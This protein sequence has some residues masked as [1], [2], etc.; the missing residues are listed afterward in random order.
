MGVVSEL[1]PRCRASRYSA[2][3]RGV[4]V[5]R[6]EIIGFIYWGPPLRQQPVDLRR[7]RVLDHTISSPCFGRQ[8]FNGDEIQGA[9]SGTA[10]VLIFASWAILIGGLTGSFSSAMGLD[11]NLNDT[12]FVVGTFNTHGRRR[13]DAS[14]GMHFGAEDEGPSTTRGGKIAARLVSSASTHVFPSSLATWAAGRNRDRRNS[15][16]FKSCRGGRG[17]A[18]GR[19]HDDGYI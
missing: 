15:S 9:I 19:L 16:S 13:R 1:V 18:R 10:D 8:E 7:S 11:I 4:I 14:R 12:Y 6:D 2:T 5:D 3:A 17:N